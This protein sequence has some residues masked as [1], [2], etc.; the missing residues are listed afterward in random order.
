MPALQSVSFAAAAF[1][2]VYYIGV[3]HYLQTHPEHLAP[4]CLFLGSSSGSVIGPLVVCGVRIDQI[5]PP[6]LRFIKETRKRKNFWASA[7]RFIQLVFKLL[8]DDAYKKCSRRC[9]VVYTKLA[10][11]TF[12]A[13]RRSRF[14]SNRDLYR[15][16]RASCCVPLVTDVGPIRLSRDHVGI[17]GTFSE[18][19]PVVDELTLRVTGTHQRDPQRADIFPPA[20]VTAARPALMQMPPPDK[21]LPIVRQGYADT[22]VYLRSI[23]PPVFRLSVNTP[24]KK[25][26]DTREAPRAWCATPP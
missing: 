24:P 19:Q 22:Q 1:N 10:L 4:G 3:M 14:R 18:N 17:D 5:M 8:P 21:I 7:R 15:Y 13:V 26:K 20:G 12:T 16:I 9:A 11:D 6:L 2:A 23:A 25:T